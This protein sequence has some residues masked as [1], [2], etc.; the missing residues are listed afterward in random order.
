MLRIYGVVL[1]VVRQVRPV[2]KEIE[3]KDSDL[4]RPWP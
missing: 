1:E 4:A 2:I 3:R